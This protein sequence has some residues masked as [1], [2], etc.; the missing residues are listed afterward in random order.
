[1]SI[2]ELRSGMKVDRSAL[3][4][5]TFVILH[6]SQNRRKIHLAVKRLK[7][8]T[9]EMD[10]VNQMLNYEVGELSQLKNR[11]ILQIVGYSSA[12]GH[13]PCL[14]Y[15]Y[16]ERGTVE[17]RLR[18]KEESG[19]PPLT[20]LERMRVLRGVAE[21]VDYLHSRQKPLIHRDIK[22]SNILLDKDMLPKVGNKNWNINIGAPPGPIW[23]IQ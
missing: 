3:P 9:L 21:A 6:L 14:V 15:P 7:E 2:S 19:E 17:K 18:S 8:S 11:F 13:P 23:S 22:S 4:S 10:R 16:L 12:P 1:M 5:R 20:A